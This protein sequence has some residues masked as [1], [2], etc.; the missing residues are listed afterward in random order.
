MGCPAPNL[1]V[2]S[3]G[4]LLFSLVRGVQEAVRFRVGLLRETL[5]PEGAPERF[6][7]LYVIVP[8]LVSYG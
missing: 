8:L 4:D 5:S 1:L 6:L 2:L 7:H 3:P